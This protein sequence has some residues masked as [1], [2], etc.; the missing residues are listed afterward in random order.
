MI[1]VATDSACDLPAGLY[2]EHDITVVPINIQF[3]TESYEDGITIDRPTFLRKIDEMGILPTTSQPSA[4]QFEQQYS[5]L[6]KGGATDIISIHVT[7]KLS[8]T[9]QSAQLAKDMVE[10]RVRVHP[11]DSACGSVGQGFMALEAAQMAEAGKSVAEILERLK[12]IRDRMNIALTLRDLRFAQM[13]GRVGR[14]QGSLASLLN[15]KPIVLLEEG[16]IDVTEKVRTRSKALNRMIAILTERVGTSEPVNLAAIHAEAPDEGRI[17]LE[18]AKSLF[19]CRKTFL[20]N[21]TTTLVVHFG[22]GTL[23]LVVYRL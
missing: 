8:G 10:G 15:I 7:A 1:K 14:L 20:C 17:L 3:G 21:L 22:P 12:T 19:D 13:S 23:G 9:Y 4:G 2:Q 18:Q 16:L 11:F 5:R 6:A